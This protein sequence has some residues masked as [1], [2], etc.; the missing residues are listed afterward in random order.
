VRVVL[1]T[2]PIARELRE[3]GSINED[4]RRNDGE[5]SPETLGKDT[6]TDFLERLRKERA[7][8]LAKTWGL[9]NCLVRDG[10]RAAEITSNMHLVT[11]PKALGEQ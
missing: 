6:H 11:N 5:D 10:K 1:V 2:P 4:K 8:P 7:I 9:L 3:H